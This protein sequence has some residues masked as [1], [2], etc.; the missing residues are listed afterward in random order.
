MLSYAIDKTLRV[1]LKK[2]QETTYT[3]FMNVMTGYSHLICE[4]VMNNR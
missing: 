4:H 2:V 3:Q 1:S